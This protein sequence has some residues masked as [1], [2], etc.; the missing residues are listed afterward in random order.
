[1]LQMKT[2]PQSPDLE[3]CGSQIWP[4]GAS[5]PPRSLSEAVRPS[6]VTHDC[7]HQH[8]LTFCCKTYLDMRPWKQVFLSGCDY[9]PNPTT[10]PGF[11]DN[12]IE[13]QATVKRCCEAQRVR[14]YLLL[15]CATSGH[16][17][18]MALLHAARSVDGE[19]LWMETNVF[20]SCFFGP[21]VT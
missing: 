3:P 20:L 8:Q 12:E 5:S 10:Q 14:C 16:D 13:K 4:N 1:M 17:K 9:Q 18:C 11:F 6:V 19:P 7:A 15:L 2:W 21:S